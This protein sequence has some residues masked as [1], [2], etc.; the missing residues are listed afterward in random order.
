MHYHLKEVWYREPIG[1]SGLT[2]ALLI[3]EL[4]WFIGWNGYN[5]NSGVCE[6]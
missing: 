2:L 5:G 3:L 1:M 4:Q 6:T